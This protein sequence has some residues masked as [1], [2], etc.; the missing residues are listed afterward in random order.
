M[1]L[2]SRLKP[3]WVAANVDTIAQEYG[4]T[5]QDFAPIADLPRYEWLNN[6]VR[7]KV[8]GYLTKMLPPWQLRALCKF[9]DNELLEGE[10]PPQL[11]PANPVLMLGKQQSGL[12]QPEPEPEKNEKKSSPPTVVASATG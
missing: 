5:A 11:K 12:L 8:I 3:D 6:E 9:V 7:A 2:R 10:Q 1:I 4:L